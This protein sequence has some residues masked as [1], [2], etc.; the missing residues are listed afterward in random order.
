MS[1]ALFLVGSIAG[2][3]ALIW[4]IVH[5]EGHIDADKTTRQISVLRGVCKESTPDIYKD[6]MIRSQQQE[7]EKEL[8]E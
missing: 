7:A 2:L 5:A 6:C 3:F 1:E 4:M 8:W